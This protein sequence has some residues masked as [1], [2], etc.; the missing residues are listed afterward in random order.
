MGKFWSISSD[1]FER[2]SH[3]VE[4]LGHAP[5]PET[6]GAKQLKT[7]PKNCSIHKIEPDYRQMNQR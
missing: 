4:A 5:D 1:D 2:L 7:K 6:Y 3:D